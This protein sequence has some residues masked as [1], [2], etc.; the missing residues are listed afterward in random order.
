MEAGREEVRIIADRLAAEF[1]DT[2]EGLSA[3]IEP[4]QERYM[5]AE[6]TRC[7]GSCSAPPSASC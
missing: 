5:P 3:D 7:C 4:Y 6:I 2:N 1:P